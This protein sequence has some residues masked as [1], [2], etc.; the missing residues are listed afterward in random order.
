MSINM[1]DDICKGATLRE[2]NRQC[3]VVREIEY[4]MELGGYM[5]KVRD[6]IFHID[7]WLYV[8]QYA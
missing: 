4:E 3:S 5:N 2:G 1:I 7:Q 6:W 8:L